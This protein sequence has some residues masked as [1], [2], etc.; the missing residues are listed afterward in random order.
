MLDLYRQQRE[1]AVASQ[2]VER[3]NRHAYVM[4]KEPPAERPRIRE[5]LAGRLSALAFHL[6]PNTHWNREVAGEPAA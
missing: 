2:Q 5:R 4:N 6:A 3:R 1:Q